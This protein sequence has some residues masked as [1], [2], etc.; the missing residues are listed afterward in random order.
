[1]RIVVNGVDS[2]SFASGA[3]LG[4]AAPLVRAQAAAE[5]LPPSKHRDEL[6]SRLNSAQV[7]AAALLRRDLMMWSRGLADLPNPTASL[8]ALS[9]LSGLDAVL[10]SCSPPPQTANLI[11]FELPHKS[12]F[13][14]NSSSS[15]AIK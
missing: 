5:S 4:D 15:L 14:S 12:S 11:H 7:G 10:E 13:P 1:M 3:K 2:A 8:S 6:K 9:A